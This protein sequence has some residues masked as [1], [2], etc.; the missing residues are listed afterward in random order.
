MK[1]YI[2]SLFISVLLLIFCV[3]A[4]AVLKEGN[5]EQSLEILRTELTQNYLEVQFSTS[6]AKDRSEQAHK[7]LISTMKKSN[8]NALMLYSQQ[9]DYIFDLTYACSEA[10]RLWQD[11]QKNSQPFNSIIQYF[12]TEIAR[13]DGLISSLHEMPDAILS[14]ESRSN[15]NVCLCL[16]TSIQRTLQNN[17][18]NYKEDIARNKAVQEHL[19]EQHEY[20]KQRYD[21][22][23][24]NI[25]SNGDKSYFSILSSFSRYY[26]QAV[27]VINTKYI[28]HTGDTR[29]QWSSD[30]IFGLFVILFIYL[31]LA[32]LLN[33]GVIHVVMPFLARHNW[34]PKGLTSDEFMKKR[35][36][37]ILCSTVFT[38]AI[39][40]LCIRSFTSQNFL[41]M[42]SGLLCE[43]TWLVAIILLSLLIR[44][45]GDQTKHGFRVYLPIIL[46]SLVVIIFRII[47][48]PSVLVNLIFPP[49]LLIFAFWQWRIVSKL[50]NDLERED[51]IYSWI[52]LLVFVF[53][54]V[55]SWVGYTLL[56]VQVL[57]WW[58][59]QLTWVLT[60]TL[61]LK[62]LV[63]YGRS[64]FGP[65]ATIN[66][67]WFY[68][69]VKTVVL[70]IMGVVSFMGS[71]FFAAKVFELTDI[72]WDIFN[73]DFINTKNF[74]L[75]IMRL[76][77][78]VCLYIFF[79][80]IM[81]VSKR[82]LKYHFSKRN[83][84]GSDGNKVVM[85]ANALS[86]LVWGVFI[87][88]AMNI[89]GVGN[90]WLTVVSGGLATGVGFA[91]KDILENIYYGISLMSGRIHIGD[92]IEI[93]GIRGTVNDMNYT[94]TMIES[95]DGSVIAFQNS[96][97]FT[98][99]YKNLTIKD[100]WELVGMPIGLAYG[101]NV[102]EAKTII[103]DTMDQLVATLVKEGNKW[104]DKSRGI[105]VLFIDFGESS[106]DLKVFCWV[107]V[108]KK[109]A[110]LDRMREAIYDAM[111]A[112]NI[113]IPFPQT[114]V[115]IIN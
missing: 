76:T 108:L 18:N 59:I 54:V 47:L 46:K 9:Y 40:L 15:R 74:H 85:G 2:F 77:I 5:L 99:N 72:C 1:K 17:L 10:T 48:I 26:H 11:F 35:P 53:S 56:S 86:I 68:G 79:R 101:T 33:I 115:H 8:Q 111:N 4:H 16:A 66:R 106:I 84:K 93:D 92:M 114:D 7:A 100:G 73:T 65:D 36:C 102:H 103:S 32:S 87:I 3:P 81:N 63:S 94:S 89:L 71:I 27:Q 95:T 91:S 19:K 70:P 44:L 90:T 41:I 110:A 82:M 6:M 58:T 12:E 45:R 20:A 31:V 107:K 64:H 21:N 14:K 62:I 112:H 42:A 51:Q 113:E 67:T 29:S 22:L 24:K 37:V 38:L 30:L 105:S 28:R 109:V 97:L 69:F 75:S 80:Y 39:I 52:T 98:K 104:I 57:I 96:Q 49:I 13:Y 60:I 88:I 43:Y 34:L 55:A 23:Q 25:F 83:L 50:H 78:V 61:L